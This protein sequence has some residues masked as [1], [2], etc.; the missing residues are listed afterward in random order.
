M[1]P[2]FLLISL[3]N[4]GAFVQQAPLLVCCRNEELH[5]EMFELKEKQEAQVEKLKGKNRDLKHDC[6]RERKRGDEGLVVAK[7]RTDTLT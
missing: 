1:S 2:K 6:E 5:I 3:G 4:P 7:V